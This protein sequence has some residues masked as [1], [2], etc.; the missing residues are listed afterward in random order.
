LRLAY[1]DDQGHPMEEWVT[2][3]TVVRPIPNGR[4]TA[5]DW[6]AVMVM[7]FRAPKGKLDGNDKL[8]KLIASTI[9]PEPE[10]QKW[11]N[12][13]IASLYRKKQEELAKQAAIVAQFQQHVADT[14]NGVVANQQAGS[15]KSVAGESQ[16]LRSV[17]TFR[18]PNTGA[19][20]ELS[21]LF[22]NAWLNTSNQ[23]LMS[24]DPTFNPTGK[25]TGNWTQLQVV[26]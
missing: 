10:W 6:H 23:Y 1:N 13:V 22:D 24:D 9:H 26:H 11:S 2:A 17:Q 12:G 7:V 20:Y 3:A 15:N 4:V 16:I 8:L 5:Y 14:I 18:D 25:L 19:L 21:N